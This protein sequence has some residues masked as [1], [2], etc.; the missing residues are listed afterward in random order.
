MSTPRPAVFQAD[1]TITAKFAEWGRSPLPPTLLATLI[2]SLHLR[3][4]QPLPMLFPP[5]LLFS[6]FINLQNFTRDAAGLTAT[7]SGIYLL[8][9]RQRKQK[10]ASGIRSRIQGRFGVRGIVRG[11][12]MGLATF[13]LVAC[14]WV[15]SL[16]KDNQ[17]ES[18]GI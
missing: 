15:Y 16:D 2:T 8:M 3:P 4:F 7:W 6:S 5:V 9:A 10:H 17:P 14:G 13:N 12:S 11:A 18:Q 1:K